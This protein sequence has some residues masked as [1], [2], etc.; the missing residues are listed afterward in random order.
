MRTTSSTRRDKKHKEREIL[1]AFL[2]AESIIGVEIEDGERPDFVLRGERVIGVE[3]TEF[4]LRDGKEEESEQ[5]QR[6]MRHEAIGQAHRL[7]LSKGPST[8]V[9]TVSFVPSEPLRPGRIGPITRQLADF[10]R[11]IEMEGEGC[12]IRENYREELPEIGF[13]YLQ[14]AREDWGKWRCQQ[15]YSP[16]PTDRS[17]LEK[18]IRR[19]E[20][21]ALGYRHC[22]AL[23]LI[24]W[25]DA[26]DPAQE[27]EI[28]FLDGGIRS[29]VFERII[30]RHSF[31]ATIDLA[32]SAES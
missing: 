15:V 21:S 24:I 17:R 20:R 31:G 4:Y 9:L 8:A 25:V 27:Q 10:V 30:L 29:S 2:T 28:S 3:V 23:W 13:L 11:R 22:D 26:F 14:R 1:R 7:Y 6:A 32:F 5:R 18:I 12:V 19:K 16:L